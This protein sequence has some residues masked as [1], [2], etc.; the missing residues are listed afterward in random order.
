MIV[1]LEGLDFFANH[2]YYEGEREIGNKYT[3]DISIEIANPQEI[4]DDNLDATVNYEIVYSKISE[5]ML[6]ST[7]LLETLAF[8]INEE[9]LKEFAK[10][11]SVESAVSKHNPPIKGVCKKASVSLKTVR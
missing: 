8:R 10:V 1:K 9:I 2:G 3:I 4:D 7:K 11:L 6:Q 5:I